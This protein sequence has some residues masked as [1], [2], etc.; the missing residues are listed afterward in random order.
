MTAGKASGSTK[1]VM[2]YKNENGS[3]SVGNRS[4]ISDDVDCGSGSQIIP[5]TENSKP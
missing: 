3:D 2:S 1:K 5:P 4:Y